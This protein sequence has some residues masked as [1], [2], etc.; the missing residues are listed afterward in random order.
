MGSQAEQRLVAAGTSDPPSR[1]RGRDEIGR[2]IEDIRLLRRTLEP[3]DR[4]IDSPGNRIFAQAVRS[5]IKDRK[6]DLRRL[7]KGR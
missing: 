5:L 7:M 6:R 1:R 3:E 4:V 2:V